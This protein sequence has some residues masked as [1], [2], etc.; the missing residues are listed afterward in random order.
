VTFESAEEVSQGGKAG[1][2]RNFRWSEIGIQEQFGS[3][4]QSQ[5]A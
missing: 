1:L 3:M 4:L 2:F 5:I